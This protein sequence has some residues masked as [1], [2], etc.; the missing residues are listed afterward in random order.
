MSPTGNFK[1]TT[2][3]LV[4]LLTKKKLSSSGVWGELRD[5]VSLV[6]ITH[7]HLGSWFGRELTAGGHG[8]WN[9]VVLILGKECLSP[10]GCMDP[11][12]KG[13]WG[14]SPQ[15]LEGRPRASPL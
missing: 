2:L 11:S 10:L 12:K 6:S 7:S 3:I 15:F 4:N 13:S 5:L 14:V 8:S 1:R 9:S